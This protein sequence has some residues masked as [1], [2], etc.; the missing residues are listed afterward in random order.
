[1]SNGEE[2]LRPR[3][4]ELLLPSATDVRRA[5]RRMLKA[6]ED[7][8]SHRSAWLIAAAAEELGALPNVQPLALTFHEYPSPEAIDADAPALMYVRGRIA[9]MRG[10]GELAVVG[11]VIPASD[12]G[13]DELRHEPMLRADETISIGI[14]HPGGRSGVRSRADRPVLAECYML[15]QPGEARWYLEPDLFAEEI[16]SLQLSDRAHRAL[17]EALASFRRGLYLACASLLGVVSEGAWY[18]AGERLRTPSILKAI[19]D[20]AGSAGVCIQVPV[21]HRSTLHRLNVARPDLVTRHPGFTR[22]E[23]RAN[24]GTVAGR[25]GGAWPRLLK[26]G[27]R[28]RPRRVRPVLPRRIAGGR[29]TV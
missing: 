21:V 26:T 28:S 6:L 4:E 11:V 14:H 24:E 8:R 9:A 16:G 7:G 22:D 19:E 3:I 25:V 1:V 5:K 13:G 23:L 12:P 10:L 15:A 2:V 20:D 27:I 29:P 17:R 18:A